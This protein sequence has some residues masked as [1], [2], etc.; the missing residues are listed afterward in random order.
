MRHIRTSASLRRFALTSAAII[1]AST[2]AY[3]AGAEQVPVF[4]PVSDWTV[5]QAQVPANAVQAGTSVPCIMSGEFDNGFVVRLSG[6]GGAV[7]AMAVDFRQNVFAKGRKY[8]AMVSLGD[9]FVKQVEAT[10]F[11]PNTLI[12]NLRPV[13]GFYA[14]MAQQKTMDVMIDNNRFRFALDGVAPQM[15]SLESCFSGEPVEMQ[16]AMADVARIQPSAGVT[17]EPITQNYE[18]PPEIAAQQMPQ[19]IGDIMQQKG[20]PTA[21]DD[22]VAPQPK[23]AINNSVPATM[24][25]EP[26]VNT[27][28]NYEQ[29]LSGRVSKTMDDVQAPQVSPYAPA[30]Q[31]PSYTPAMS[32]NLVTPYPAE[33]AAAP[34]APAPAAPAP[35][36]V[37]PKTADMTQASAP[38]STPTSLPSYEWQA[39]AGE[40]VKSVLARWSDKAGYDLQWDSKNSGKVSTNMSLNGDFKTAVDI[41]LSQNTPGSSIVARLDNQGIN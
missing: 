9:E 17:Q 16:T 30:Y 27:A 7:M 29:R 5:A 40:D 39:F 20:A 19:N 14:Q 36:A 22:Y 6:G 25:A 18:L 28:A 33:L 34:A 2:G 35:S 13:E 15:A 31:D 4:S 23:E 37:Y 32:G 21:P 8:T 24:T 26:A 12:F 3:A 11:A 38:I 41:L 10:A 1:S